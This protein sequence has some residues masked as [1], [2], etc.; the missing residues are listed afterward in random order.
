MRVATT[1]VG[2]PVENPYV[3]QACLDPIAGIRGLVSARLLGMNGADVNILIVFH[4]PLRDG[5][6][7][8]LEALCSLTCCA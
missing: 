3:P 5:K 4:N 1:S 7:E 8:R 2:W 6:R